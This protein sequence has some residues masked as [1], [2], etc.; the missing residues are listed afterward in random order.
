VLDCGANLLQKFD[1]VH[2]FQIIDL[3]NYQSLSS[4]V[5]CYV[6]SRA[7]FAI[8]KKEE[9]AANQEALNEKDQTN[10]RINFHQLVSIS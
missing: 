10:I 6:A 4:F 9:A 2:R 1:I 5:V 7:K 3:R 8:T